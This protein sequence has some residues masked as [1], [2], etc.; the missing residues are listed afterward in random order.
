MSPAP[1]VSIFMPVYNGEAYIDK[2]VQSVLNQTLTDFELIC[3]DDSSTDNSLNILRK[4]ENS[5]KRV[6]VL[7]KLNGGNVPKSWNFAMPFLNGKFIMYMSQDDWMSSDNLELNHQRYLQTGADIIVPDLIF[8]YKEGKERK[9]VG[10]NGNHDIVISGRE[11]FILSL[12]WKIHGFYFCKAKLMK[13]EIFDEM[14]FNSDEYISRKNFLIANKVAFSHGHFY[15]YQ[16]NPNAITKHFTI[17]TLTA[18]I[19]DQK[20]FEL[21]ER[22]EIRSSVI[23]SYWITSLMRSLLYY[24]KTKNLNK[25]DKKKSFLLLEHHFRYLSEKSFC[26]TPIISTII[27]M[28]LNNWLLNKISIAN[29]KSKYN[30]YE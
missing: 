10:L 14:S 11:A 8:H 12:K 30:L 15:Y 24:Y 20:L 3:V 29:K 23:S 2:S 18:L 17:N 13:T 28:L 1:L 9:I 6:K 25:E 5:D 4:Y 22:N 26:F 7:T 21:M 16:G 19:T 27:K